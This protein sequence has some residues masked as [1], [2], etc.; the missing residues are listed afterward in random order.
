MP[1]R[2]RLEGIEMGDFPARTVALAP[3]GEPGRPSLVLDRAR[4]DE[5]TPGLR[6]FQRVERSVALADERAERE[7]RRAAD[8]VLAMDQDPLSG[9]E[10]AHRESDAL[11]QHGLR[12]RAEIVGRE[13]K[14]RETVAAKNL[15]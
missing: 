10:V 11:V 14:E 12:D 15:F 5:G 1:V 6:E 2:D 3:P 8:A 13:V 7:R 4:R 9:V